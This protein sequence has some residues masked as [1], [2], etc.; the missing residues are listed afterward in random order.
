MQGKFAFF[1]EFRSCC[2][3]SHFSTALSGALVGMKKSVFAEKSGINRSAVSE[4][5]NG[6]RLP[7]SR[8]DKIL[9]A[10]EARHRLPILLGYLRDMASLR[11][12]KAG[13][14][15]T[16]YR[17]EEASPDARTPY[18]P[19]LAGDFEVILRHLHSPEGAHYAPVFRALA[20]A[21]RA[22][23]KPGGRQG[24]RKEGKGRSPR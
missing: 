12:G 11:G 16:A 21:F 1:V 8:L 23:A 6:K 17:I 20:A 18:P 4:F 13:I 2:D 10:V 22:D 14:P 24:A 15:P 3:M 9:E 19:G 7:D 5:C